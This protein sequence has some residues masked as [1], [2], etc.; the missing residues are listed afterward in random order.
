M[1]WEEVT[2]MS[3]RIQFIHEAELKETTFTALCKSYCI[4]VKTG[5][6]WLNRYHEQG[7]DGLNDLSRKPHNS[8]HRIASDIVEQILSLRHQ[9]PRLGGRKIHF[10]LRRRGVT[11]VPAPSTI[12]DI[13]RR[14]GLIDPVEAKKHKAFIRFEHELPNQLWQMDFK[15]HFALDEGR[16]H[17]LTVLDDHSRFCVGLLACPNERGSI[18]QKQLTAVFRR[19]GI[20]QRMTMDNGAPWGKDA[21]HRLTKFTV[22]LI[23]LGIKVSHSSPYHPQTQGKD[24]RFHRSL[25]VELLNYRLIGNMEQAQHEFDEW[26][27]FYNFQRPHEALDMLVP[28]DRYKPSDKIFP[29]SLPKIEY[30]ESDSV[31]KVQANGEIHFRGHIFRISYALHGYPVAVRQTDQDGIFDVFFCNERV[32]CINLHETDT[33]IN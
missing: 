5:Y 2:V 18:V 20:P 27:D 11:S 1:P 13:L 28:N 33:E 4:S 24:E 23:R 6:K 12:T 10:M 26:L 31:R 19:Y 15:G 25:K 3:L 30:Q 16:C 7:V 32:K 9:Y 8:P 14:N 29:E 21:V 17:P 22:W